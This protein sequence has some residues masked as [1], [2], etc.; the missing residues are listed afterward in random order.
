MSNDSIEL[1]SQYMKLVGVPTLDF[2]E[3]GA[4]EFE[5]KTIGIINGSA[6][7]TLWGYYFGKKHLPGAKLASVGNEAVQLNFMRAHNRGEPCPP[8]INIKLFESYAKQ[9][10]E[11]FKMDALVLTCSTMNR[12]IESVRSNLSTANIP[13]IQVDESMMEEAVRIGGKALVIATHGPTVAN[14]QSLLR[15]TGKRLNKNIE[16]TGVTVESAF[17]LLGK[18][19]IRAHNKVIVDAIEEAIDADTIDSVILAQISMAVFSMEFPDPTKT[20][21]VPVLNSGDCGFMAA[22]S[23]LIAQSNPR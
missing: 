3:Q 2:E 10:T 11:L 14:T 12:A 20:F 6:W 18:G 22:R 23:S 15:E 19:E 13:I 21:G 8:L 5:G 4:P 1:F 16:Y 7:T 17:H 9:L